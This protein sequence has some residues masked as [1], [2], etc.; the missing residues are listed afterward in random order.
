MIK[1]MRN[2]VLLALLLFGLIVNAQNTCNTAAAVSAGVTSISNIDGFSD[3]HIQ[4]I[5]SGLASNKCI[6]AGF[7][8]KH[9][10][11]I[12]LVSNLLI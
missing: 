9:I 1:D 12:F 8:D 6:A 3:K 2:L 7:F 11:F 4:F 5:L 10:Q